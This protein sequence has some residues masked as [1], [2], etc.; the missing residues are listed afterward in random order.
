MNVLGVDPG[1]S[2]PA[3]S[4]VERRPVGWHL[5]SSPVLHS[6]DDLV[7]HL[8]ELYHRADVH[9][10]C[11]E[12]VSWTGAAGAIEAYRA[13]DIKLAVGAAMQFAKLK[14][15]PFVPVRPQTWHKNFGVKGAKAKERAREM[16]RRRCTGIPKVFGL[17]RSDAA[18]IAIAGAGAMGRQM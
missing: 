9:C 14:R 6:L 18:C 12:D 8:C 4:L 2:S 3:A 16:L 17:N 13:T 1:T 10:V 7:D 5:L 11:C 15:V